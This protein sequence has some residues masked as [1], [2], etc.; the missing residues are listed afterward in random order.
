MGEEGWYATKIRTPIPPAIDPKTI[1]FCNAIPPVLPV[2]RV[3]VLPKYLLLVS[4]SAISIKNATNAITRTRGGN[5][6]LRT[7]G[8]E[9]AG[10]GGGGF[11]IEGGWT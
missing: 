7:G 8:G 11:G 1:N 3:V 5:L 9:I 10:F 4:T 6:G 2:Y